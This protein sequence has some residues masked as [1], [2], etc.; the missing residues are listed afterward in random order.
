[1]ANKAFSRSLS[2]TK[3]LLVKQLRPNSSKY[4]NRKSSNLSV[5]SKYRRHSSFAR[6]DLVENTTLICNVENGLLKSS[7][8]FPYFM[9]V[10]F[11]AGSVLRALLLLLLYPFMC[12]VKTEETRLKM[13][14]MVC[15]C[16]IRK[17]G[18]RI[19]AS[20]LPKFLL[21]NV[22]LEG[23]EVMKKARVVKIVGVSDMPQ[24]MI[25]PFLRDYM[26][27][28][29][30]VGTELKVFHGYFTGLMEDKKTNDMPVD[31]AASAVVGISS[32]NS[33]I[34]RRLVS[35]C[36]EIFLTNES[37]RSSWKQLPKEKYPEPL[38]FHDGRL[39]F[40]PTVFSCIAMFMWFPFGVLLAVVRGL[41]A[42]LLPYTIAGI[43][44]A[45]TGMN[46]QLTTTNAHA[47]AGPNS[48]GVLY[49]CNHRTLLDP[50]YLCFC[51]KKNLTAVTYSLSR[52]SEIL[53]P[54][55]TVRLTRSLSKDSKL[56]D[57]MLTQGDLVVCPEGT[58]CREP[59]LLRFSPLFTE[60]SE[61][62]VPVAMDSDVSMF[63]GTTAGGLKCLD[64]IFFLMNPFPSYHVKFLDQ[65][66]G[67]SSSSNPPAD[68]RD[69]RRF[70]VA[71]QVQSALGKSLNFES[72]KLTRKDKYL[73]LAGNE[74]VV[75]TKTIKSE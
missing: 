49:V 62:I 69:S 32:V 11:E 45:F 53:A 70:D 72:T 65:V 20:V 64:P 7:N 27:F 59:Y 57:Q 23:F 52:L 61:T 38:I 28:D 24:V 3:R 68:G 39:A 63:Y 44:L 35:G 43:L 51:L 46:L 75:P 37:E 1:M 58:T 2:V 40:R 36:D 15:F 55:K 74:G 34:D 17:D 14:V 19:G 26:G 56:M 9:L 47:S 13:M 66:Q 21:E 8:L 60:M 10:A 12:L 41:I 30:V 71:N 48:K 5:R 6:A 16:G 22:G 67:L 31:D 50:L 29:G 42:L 54:I 25:E 33:S 4:L 73:V 18:F